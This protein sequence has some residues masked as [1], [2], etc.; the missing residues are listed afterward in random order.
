MQNDGRYLL[1]VQ[2]HGSGI[3]KENLK[4]ITEPFFTENKSRSRSLGGAG[5]GLALCKQIAALHESAI[6][7]DSA[8]G[9]G[10]A[11]SILLKACQ[12]SRQTKDENE[13][14]KI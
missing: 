12:D 11:A 5:L 3:K 4:K 14:E 1:I 8:P 2:D 9:S 6:V 10:T 7:F 13:N